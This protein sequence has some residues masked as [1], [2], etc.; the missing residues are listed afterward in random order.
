MPNARIIYFVF[1]GDEWKV[2]L[3]KL[4]YAG[5]RLSLVFFY[6][7]TL[8]ALKLILEDRNTKLQ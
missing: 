1:L 7:D 3:Q 4:I 8:P 6:N 2:G 5:Q